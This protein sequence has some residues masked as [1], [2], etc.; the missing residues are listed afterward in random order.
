MCHLFENW[1]QTTAHQPIIVAAGAFS[2]IITGQRQRQFM[3]WGFPF[4][5][6]TKPRRELKYRSVTDTRIA[7]LDGILWRDSFHNRRCLIPIRR[8]SLRAPTN[9]NSAPIWWSLPTGARFYAAGLW[10]NSPKWG[11]V[12]SMVMMPCADGAPIDLMPAIL[13]KETVA[14]W[15]MGTPAAALTAVM[16]QESIPFIQGVFPRPYLAPPPHPR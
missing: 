11:M 12:F 16:L 15:L 14:D 2:L 13:S 10:V 6:L 1:M 5:I 4:P 3:T 9:S 8:F 7:N